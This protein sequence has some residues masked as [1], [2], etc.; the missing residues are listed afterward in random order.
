MN[1]TVLI[2]KFDVLVFRYMWQWLKLQL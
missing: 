1:D 2:R